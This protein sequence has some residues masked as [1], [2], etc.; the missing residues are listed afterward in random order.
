MFKVLPMSSILF[1]LI[2]LLI[3]DLLILLHKRS[4]ILG[5]N[6]KINQIT[7]EYYESGGEKL[8]LGL[9]KNIEEMRK[10]NML[11]SYNLEIN[12]EVKLF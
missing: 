11:T 8:A 3:V 6:V 4:N 9:D 10:V 7:G 1:I 2:T 12:D 5:R